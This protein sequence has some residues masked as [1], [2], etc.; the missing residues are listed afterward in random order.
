MS[1]FRK[2]GVGKL[3][4]LRVEMGVEGISKLGRGS[5]PAEVWVPVGTSRGRCLPWLCPQKAEGRNEAAGK[6]EG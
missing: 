5:A 1:F 6:E 2:I 4:F 3:Y